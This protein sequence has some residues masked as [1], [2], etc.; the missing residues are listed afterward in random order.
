MAGKADYRTLM[1]VLVNV[2]SGSKTDIGKGRLSAKSGS[3]RL[4]FKST[5]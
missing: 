3:S 4:H 2:S 1:V 5:I